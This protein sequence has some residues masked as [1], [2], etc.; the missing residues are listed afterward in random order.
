MTI[1][2]GSNFEAIVG[3]AY[4]ALAEPGV[5]PV[6]D[7]M[8]GQNLL[9]DNMFSFYLTSKQAENIGMESDLTFGYYDKSKFKGDISWHPIKYQYMFGVQLDDIKFNGQSSGVCKNGKECL[10]TFDSGTSLMSVPTFASG[11]LSSSHIP[12]ANTP[13]PCRSPQQFGDM[14]LVINGKDYVVPNDEWTLP[15]QPMSMAQGGVKQ[16][17]KLGPLGPQLMA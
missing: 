17:I 6:F 15:V 12:T 1:F 8:M 13:V 9:Q 3:L 5:K 14:T 11:V 2:T 4:P 16:Q 10:I 7:E